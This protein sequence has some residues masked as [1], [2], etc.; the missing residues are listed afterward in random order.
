M[1]DT[2]IDIDLEHGLRPYPAAVVETVLAIA[3]ACTLIAAACHRG[4]LMQLHG[5]S[6]NRNS[7]GE[8]QKKL[9]LYADARIAEM[10][11]LCPAVAGWASEEHE[12]AVASQDHAASGECLVAFDPLDGSSN[13]ESNISVGTIFSVL[14]HPL[15]GAA[16]NSAAFMQPGRHQLAAGYVIYGPSTVLVLS[17]GCGVQMFT[18]DAANSRWVLTRK[19]VA[20]PATTSEFA[21]NCSNQRFWEKPVQRY[22]D[23]CIAGSDGPRGRDFSM[24]WV[25]S[26]VADVH[27]I[28]TRGGVFL[29]PREVGESRKPGRLRLLY[30]AA[31]MAYL[32]EQA[33][34]C[35]VDGTHAL[36]DLVP[37]VLH[38][39]VPVILGSRE[40]V[41]RV[42]RYHAET[43]EPVS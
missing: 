16:I 38:Q 20:I 36:L 19:V 6:G 40:E 27:R 23:E 42:V 12:K 4:E 35:A 15:R 32:V 37:A 3:R 14:P 25:A 43:G 26:M 18:L 29:Y 5:V 11:G 41:E 9:D 7:Q 2:D 24:R 17:M 30:E 22:V 31:P 1:T 21:V 13:I 10:L 39:R 34:G 28:F 33:G 8:A